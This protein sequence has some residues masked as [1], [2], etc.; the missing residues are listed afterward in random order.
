MAHVGAR[1]VSV[2]AATPTVSV[3]VVVVTA[4]RIPVLHGGVLARWHFEPLTAAGE[5]PLELNIWRIRSDAAQ[6]GDRLLQRCS[7]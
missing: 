6:D 5:R 2:A 1:L 7:S 4:V 3:V